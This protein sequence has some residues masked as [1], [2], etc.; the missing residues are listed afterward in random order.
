MNLQMESS[1]R[2]RLNILPRADQ[3]TLIDKQMTKR[4]SP[5]TLTLD[6]NGSIQECS[7]SIETIFG[8]HPHELVWQHISC[9]FPRFSEVALIQG[10]Q[11]NP[12]LNYLCHCDHVFEATDKRGDVVICNLNFFIVENKGTPNL[13]LIVRPVANAKS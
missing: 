3:Q 12:M 7:N 5:P 13:K 8:Y 11:L 6:A 4:Q 2:S 10:N 9:L 1:N